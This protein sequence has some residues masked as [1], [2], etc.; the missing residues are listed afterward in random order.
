MWRGRGSRADAWRLKLLKVRESAGL[1]QF[2]C[3]HQQLWIIIS[4]V[5]KQLICALLLAGS[6]FAADN[7]LLR[8]GFAIRH[9]RREALSDGTITR[10]YVSAANDDFIDVRTADIAGFVEA[11]AIPI[12]TATPK[13]ATPTPQTLAEIVREASDKTLLDEDLL[14]SVISAESGANTKAVSRKGAQGLMQLMPQ[15]AKK[16]GVTDAFDP[17]ANVNGGSRYLHDMLVR[18]NFDLAKAL[19]AYNAGP[20]AVEKYKGVPPYRETR[21][22]VAHIIKDYNR[23]KLAQAATKRPTAKPAAEK[24]ASAQTPSPAQ[25]SKS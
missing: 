21:L 11:P 4:R 12:P 15:T 3:S 20:E 22:Y 23:K 2:P 24:S 6:A 16:L 19:A 5:R 8:N 10:L 7:A 1:R 25:P 17:R 9:E 18:F 13:P 14:Y